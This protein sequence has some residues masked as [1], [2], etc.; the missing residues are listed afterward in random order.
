MRVWL[1]AGF[2]Q[3]ASGS[4]EQGTV[5]SGVWK[6]WS[7]P[8]VMAIRPMVPVADILE[9]E[10]IPVLQLAAVRTTGQNP[11]L[12]HLT[13]DDETPMLSSEQRE[14]FMVEACTGRQ[15]QWQS[16]TTLEEQST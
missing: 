14:A 1:E 16:D 5:S 8:I 3:T 12:A 15:R 6:S 7:R 11:W 4:V 9:D 2:V 13:C 10:Q